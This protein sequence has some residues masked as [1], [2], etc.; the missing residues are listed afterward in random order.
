MIRKLTGTV[1]IEFLLLVIENFYILKYLE[2]F[3]IGQN[4]Y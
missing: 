4:T 1:D 3:E 2:Y